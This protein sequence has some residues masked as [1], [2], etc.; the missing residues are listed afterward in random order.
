[1]TT[2]ERRSQAS[3]TA[4]AVPSQSNG[5]APQSSPG[6]TPATIA[7]RRRREVRRHNPR[8]LRHGIFA[9]VLNEPDVMVEVDLLF[10][11]H[12]GLDR[13]DDARLVENLAQAAVQRLRA[14]KAMGADLG[15]LD[16]DRLRTLTAYE[17]KLA[18]LI[19]RL[20]RTVHERSEARLAASNRRGQ[21]GLDRY[22]T[23]TK[24]DSR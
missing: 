13:L 18:P 21:A 15:A 16:N 7:G 17:A 4:S 12:P 8:A 14:V 10:A 24:G 11:T 9:D 20:E 2:A 1:M 6:P 22:R 19:E 23:P 3:A 5:R